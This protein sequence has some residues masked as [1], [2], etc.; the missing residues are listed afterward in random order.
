MK[1][2][3]KFE[4]EDEAKFRKEERAIRKYNM[5]AFRTLTLEYYPQ[6]RDGNFLGQIVSKNQKKHT[7]S[8]ELQL[9]TDTLFS[10][11]HGDITVHYTVRTD[12]N[13][14]TFEKITPEELL[15]EG[16]KSELDTYK[17]VMISKTH[18]DKDMFKI[19][20]LNMLN[21]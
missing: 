12:E 1:N 7:V 15:E 21:R 13:V 20:L 6:L 10:K 2:G 18:K 17:G 16:H 8:Y 19:N 4:F 11:V 9:P 3:Y 5:L 14:L